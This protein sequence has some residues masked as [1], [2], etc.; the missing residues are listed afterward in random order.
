MRKISQKMPGGPRRAK[1]NYVPLVQS[2]STSPA[3]QCYCVGMHGEANTFC[4]AIV[5]RKGSKEAPCVQE[6]NNQEQV[7]ATVN[8]KS[9]EKLS[10]YSVSTLL[11]YMKL[12]CFLIKAFKTYDS[13]K[14]LYSAIKMEVKKKLEEYTLTVPQLIHI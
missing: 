13:F 4:N 2:F 7:Y 14:V 12:M 8:R 11:T 1:Q 5:T 9:C 6:R 3:G 10:R